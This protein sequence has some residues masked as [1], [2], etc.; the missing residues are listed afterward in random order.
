MISTITTGSVSSSIFIIILAP[1][2]T[3]A[4]IRTIIYWW[5]LIVLASIS[6]LSYA[7]RQMGRLTDRIHK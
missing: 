1:T 2:T 5:C 6:N 4:P 7:G 3:H